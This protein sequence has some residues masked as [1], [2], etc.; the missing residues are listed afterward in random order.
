MKLILRRVTHQEELLWQ[1]HGGMLFPWCDPPIEYRG[2]LWWRVDNTPP[3]SF[4]GVG[5]SWAYIKKMTEK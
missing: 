1:A 3:M 5:E 2:K 4:T